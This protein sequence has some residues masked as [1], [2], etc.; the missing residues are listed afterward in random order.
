[1]STPILLSDK[2]TLAAIKDYLRRSKIFVVDSS[3]VSRARLSNILI[4]LGALST[5]V[6][7]FGSFET[8]EHY[9][10]E[11]RPQIVFSDYKIGNRSGFDLFQTLNQM[12]ITDP[13]ESLFVL[14]TANSSQS[15]VAQAAEEDIDA[16]IL[17][18]YTIDM[19]KNIFIKTALDK[20]F[21]SKYMQLIAKGKD[22]LCAGEYPESMEIFEEAKKL[23]DNPTLACFYYGQAEYMIG[24]LEDAEKSYKNGLSF[25]KIHYKCLVGLFD[26]MMEQKQFEEAYD[27]VRMIAE[28]FPA[29]PERLGQIIHLAITTKNF[30]DIE[31][32]YNF[33][34]NFNYRTETLINYICA[35][36]LICGKYYL[37]NNYTD[38]AFALFEKVSITSKGHPKFLRILIE[39]LT[40][41]KQH[42]YYTQY[43][44]RFDNESFET[45]DFKIA[46]F[47]T[48]HIGMKPIKIVNQCNDFIR[49]GMLSSSL[50]YLLIENNKKLGRIEEA[51]II[52]KNAIER[53]P[54][55]TSTFYKIKTE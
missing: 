16:F 38:R 20:L 3:G 14:I 22:L 29:N 40:E 33:F 35:S 24:A 17:K 25:N 12:K 55:K 1:M 50:Y 6:T 23:A 31:E 26:L 15:V 32:Y 2:K 53:W 19:V 21:P 43:L 52:Y 37:Q 51:E 9:Y 5:N 42:D 18:P 27:V 54:E 41:F 45:P 30:S 11:K 46:H 47:L 28:Y 48:Q 10:K 44:R 4:E 49:N 13:K 39:Y 36:L 8:A 34:I 7:T